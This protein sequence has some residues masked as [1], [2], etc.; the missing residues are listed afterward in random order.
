MIDRQA[1]RLFGR[2]IADRSHHQARRGVGGRRTIGRNRSRAGETEVQ[3]LHVSVVRDDDIGRLEISMD[4]AAI[5]RGGECPRDLD[6]VFNR[7]ADW[8]RPARDQVGERFTVDEL[9]DRVRG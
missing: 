3:D 2:H 5:V 1:A 8:Q 6:A 7:L 4:N 9:G